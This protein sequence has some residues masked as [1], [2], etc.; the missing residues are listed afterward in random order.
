MSFTTAPADEPQVKRRPVAA[1]ALSFVLV[2]AGIVVMIG[3]LSLAIE[4]VL[5]AADKAQAGGWVV[6]LPVIAAGLAI[7]FGGVRFVTRLRPWLVRR[8]CGYEV[9][10]IPAALRWLATADSG[11]G[12]Y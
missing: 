2:A 8:L 11:G 9:P 6:A 5:Q 12:G 4:A 3:G 10:R 1:V 7:V